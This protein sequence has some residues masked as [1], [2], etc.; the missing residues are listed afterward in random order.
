MSDETSLLGNILL[1]KLPNEVSSL[2]LN[3]ENGTNR[4]LKA[5]CQIRALNDFEALQCWLNEYRHKEATFR[6][7]QKEVERFLLWSIHQKQKP[8]SSLDRDDL[9]NYLE[10]LENPQPREFWC[11]KPG[12]R[13]CRRGDP[14]WRP[15]TGALSYSAR[16]TAM[17]AIDSMMNYLV[18]ARYLAFNPLSLIRKCKQTTNPMQHAALKMEERMLAV[19]EWHTM[20]DTLES[21]PEVNDTK[22]REK[23][24]LKF[25]VN[26]L[27]FLG[28]RINELAT[29]SWN[30][31]RKVD[32]KWWFYVV[33]KGDKLGRIPVNNGLLKAIIIYRA[34][35]K[36]M[37][38]PATDEDT[39][40]IASFT[41]GDAITPRQINKILKRLAFETSKK[42]SGHPEKVMKMKK[43][44]AHWLRHLS[45]SMQDRAGVQFKHIRA[46]H[47]HENDETTRRYVHAID[48]D[49][50]QDMQKLTLRM[51]D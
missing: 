51:L 10:F 3:G 6:T 8:L 14:L 11:A 24:R 50:H 45:A 13:K 23:A 15:F 5:K 17:S 40:L 48:Q 47:R 46:N 27:Y 33:G 38:Y 36:K 31:F 26:I 30:A 35:L 16:L 7:Y 22:K 39:P 37:P 49:R 12:G 29:H 19:D 21:L 42:F 18:D 43:F 34:F 1:L 25:L 28:L 20:L 9:E 41:T 2:H 44:S 4:E 32:D